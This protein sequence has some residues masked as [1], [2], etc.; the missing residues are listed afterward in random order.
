MS[1]MSILA[2]VKKDSS[3]GMPLAAFARE[4]EQLLQDHY[5][6]V[7]SAAVE[8]ILKLQREDCRSLTAAEL[9]QQGFCDPVRV[10]VKQE[11]H[12][13]E[14][15]LVRRFRLIFSV[16]LVDQ[17]I[18]RFLCS[19][20]NQAEI[21]NWEHLA[22]CPGMGMS[23]DT[24][25]Q[26]LWNSVQEAEIERIASSDISGYD[27]SV[28]GFEL[29]ADAEARITLNGHNELYAKIIRNR[30]HCLKWKVLALSDGRLFAQLEEGV[31]AS[32]S[33]N[34]SSTNSRMRVNA[35]FFVG[36]E[37]AKA[38]GDDALEEWVADA[39]AR[40][41]LLGKTIK[42]YVPFHRGDTFEFCSHLFKPGPVVE[43]V[44][45][46]RSLYRLLHQVDDKASHLAEL[47][48]LLRWSPQLPEALLAVVRTGWCSE[49][50]VSEARAIANSG[51]IKGQEEE[52]ESGPFSDAS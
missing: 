30:V 32:G 48:V 43:P 49:D 46:A 40:Y 27:W 20:Q 9:V 34:T 47:I 41:K 42:E 21:A 39:V 3:P 23:L 26:S 1:V 12:L 38:M 22:S 7:A 14:K 4:N 51:Q 29:D 13:T 15:V 11:P 44:N 5:W 17:V 36:A 45:W 16:S 50:V 35:A 24:Q 19:T 31:Q 25:V 2:Q 18:E 8:R 6:L 52:G 37:W 33:Y 10:F 28:Q